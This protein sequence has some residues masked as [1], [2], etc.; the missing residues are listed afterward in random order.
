MAHNPFEI[1]TD[2]Q[3][4][5]HFKTIQKLSFKQCHYFNLI[6]DFNFHIKY[7][8]KKAN[9]KADIF[10]RM[11]N[12]ISDDK[13]EK[14]QRCYQVLLSSKQFQIAILK[15]GESMQQGTSGKHN[16]YEWVKE[17]NQVDRELKQI[18]KRCVK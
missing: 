5:K 18:K 4:L 3:V 8:S 17:V 13:D 10:I 12:C 16:F 15:G 2:N 9:V 7:Y 11:L 14:I 6:S 1:L